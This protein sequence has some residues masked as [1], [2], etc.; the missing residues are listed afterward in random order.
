[1]LK[2]VLTH[3]SLALVLLLGAVILAGSAAHAA[4]PLEAH[5]DPAWARPWQNLNG[6]WRFEF[7][8]EDQGVKDAWFENHDYSKS[9]V[10][11]YPWQS[12][13]SGIGDA[14]Y[15]GAA[16]YE[17]DV[18]I[19]A[20][21]GPRVFLM[22]GA[23]DWEASVWVN[24]KHAADHVGGYTPSEVELTDAGKPG[25]TVRVTVRA[26]DVTDPET[27]NGKQTGWYTQTGGIWQTV[28][29]ESRGASYVRQAHVYPDVDQKKATIRCAVEVAKK[30]KYSLKALTTA[31]RYGEALDLAP[32]TA[33]WSG[34]LEAG[35][36]QVEIEV[37]V[38]NPEL[39][40]P[41]SPTL[42]PTALTLS[43]N[44]AKDTVNTYFGM[45]KVSR[46]TYNGSKY[47]YILLN[48]KPIYLRG[49]L[50]QSF[51]P[52]GVY[53]HPDDDFIRNDYAKAKEY[54]LNFIR[55][56]I[57]V[58]EPR[59]LYWADRLGVLLMCDI[60]NYQK[61]TPRSQALWEDTMRATLVRDFNHPSVFSWCCFNETWGIRDGGFGP[62]TQEWVRDMYLLTKELDPTR[63]VED[64]SPCRYDHVETDINSWHFYIDHFDRAS[65][66][67]AE[68]VEKTFPG[69][70][71]NYTGDWKQGTAPLINSEYGGVSAGS[72]DR[73]ISWVFLFLTNLLR[74]Y[75]M[76]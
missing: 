38:P 50:H 35:T 1:M 46:G 13:L 32:I 63:L 6:A 73:D 29:L 47:E 48:D 3:S 22:F 68:V 16:W 60:P 30:G 25:D 57:K 74:R 39:W 27:P 55:I 34:E 2:P 54:G 24:G 62:A 52:E 36:Q 75:D 28:Y 26:F 64:N 76:I 59:C 49:A 58:D 9:I 37:P 70:D 11:P 4:E 40:T 14:K 61:H 66:H 41:E 56:H 10:V 21:A 5:P 51:N 20:D 42:Y 45:R 44:G 71:F 23:V 17:R 18:T 43:G 33:A 8:P 67:I 72:G 15:R 12:E 53:T 19:P 65:H 31:E 7:D 69:S